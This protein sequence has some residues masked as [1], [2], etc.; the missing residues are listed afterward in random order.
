MIAGSLG[1]LP[2]ASYSTAGPTLYEPIHGSAPDIAGQNIANPIGM[3]RSMAMMLNDFDLKAGYVDV[4]KALHFVL[5]QGIRTK[6]LGG[7]AST[8]EFTQ[9]MIA[10]LK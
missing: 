3:I 10:V 7:T 4:E 5:D 9:A 8:T 2:S 1:L 6:D